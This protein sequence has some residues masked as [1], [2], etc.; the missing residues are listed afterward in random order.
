MNNLLYYYI[1]MLITEKIKTEFL[2]F[3]E[4]N[5]WLAV[6]LDKNNKDL[7]SYFKVE[8]RQYLAN[9]L[10]FTCTFNSTAIPNWWKS[11]CQ[12]QSWTL[13]MTFWTAIATLDE[14]FLKASKPYA[15]LAMA[16]TRAFSKAMRN[17]YGWFAIDCWY[18]PTPLEEM[19]EVQWVALTWFSPKTK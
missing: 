1:I 17:Y 18:A 12:L 2:A 13:T 9:L 3:M 11:E 15:V 16:E 8:A 7:W 19:I 5:Q 10:W 6:Q 4:K 14:E